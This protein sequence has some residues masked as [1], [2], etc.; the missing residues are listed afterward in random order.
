MVSPLKHPRRASALILMLASACG[1][2]AFSQNGDDPVGS[3][4][5]QGA[6]GAGGSAAQAGKSSGGAPSTAG[7]TSAAGNTSG[8]V[9]SADDACTAAPEP[10]SCEAYFP[11]WYHD[12]STGVCRP[13]V[14]GGCN[15]NANRYSSLAECQTSCYGRS[16]NYASCR[17]TSDCVV[18]TS[19]C[20]G[21]C[22]SSSFSEHDVIAFNQKYQDRFECAIPLKLPTPGGDQGCPACA[23]VPD[24]KQKYFLPYCD[25]DLCAVMNL[26][27]SD[28][29]ACVSDSDC[30]LRRGSDCC[31]SCST[32]ELLSVRSDGSFE[33]YAC[34]GGPVACEACVPQAT[35]AIP[36]CANGH[37]TF[38][39]PSP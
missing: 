38:R 14:Y 31:E 7:N 2:R 16:P 23:A 19:S 20:C 25:G 9:S 34:S 37:C 30:R 3:N 29:T 27:T 33:S 24:G 21:V 35:D 1:G 32:S 8:G 18:A 17:Q 13:F 6:N 10:G 26:Q 12:A 5:G 4:G 22:D 15:G 36:F 28:L 39:F 11:V